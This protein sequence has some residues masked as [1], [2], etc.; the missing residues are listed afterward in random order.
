[1]LKINKKII[2]FSII[3]LITLFTNIVFARR[4]GEFS[5]FRVSFWGNRRTGF[6]LKEGA[7]GSNYVLNLWPS[8]EFKPIKVKNY[9]INTNGSRRSDDN[10]VECGKRGICSNWASRGYSYALRMNRENIWDRRY[11]R[12]R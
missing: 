4:I 10:L 11:N 9:L 5:S 1:M 7:D 6:L 2:F 8:R 3:I 12:N